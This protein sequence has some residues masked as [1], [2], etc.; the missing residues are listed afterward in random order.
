VEAAKTA[1]G[2]RDRRVS[3]EAQKLMKGFLKK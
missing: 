1:E 2:S 3:S